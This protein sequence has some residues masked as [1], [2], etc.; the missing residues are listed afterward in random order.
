[1]TPLVLPHLLFIT[2][3]AASSSSLVSWDLDTT[4]GGLSAYGETAQWSWGELSGGPQTDEH[5]YAWGTGV[6]RPYLNDS[7]DYLQLPSFDLS[8]SARPVLRFY[9]WYEVDADGTDAGW[10]EFWD[11]STWSRAEPIYDY[12]TE[13]GYA[14]NSNGWHPAWFDLRGIADATYLRFAFVAD[15]RVALAGWF[16]DDIEILDGDPVPPSVTLETEPE[17]TQDLDG[18]YTVQAWVQDDLLAPS[19][20]LLWNTGEESGVVEMTEEFTGLFL[21]EIPGQAP[22]TTVRW[23]V[24][25]SDG[26]NESAQPET[27]YES[28]RVYLAA[29]TG[30]TGPSGRVVGTTVPLQWTPPESDHAVLGYHVY[31]DDVLVTTNTNPHADAPLCS[32]APR[33]SVSAVYRE[34]EGDLSDPLT[35]NAAIPTVTAMEPDSAWQGERVRLQVS[36][37]YLLLVPGE[38]SLDLGEG[39]QVE[40][41]E[42]VDSNTAI[43]TLVIDAE[44]PVG[45]REAT[46]LT[47]DTPLPLPSPLTLLDGESRP[48][49]LS[50][51][52]DALTQGETYTLEITANADFEG[53][54][55]LD[56]GEGLVVEAITWSGAEAVATVAVTWSAPIGERAIEADDGARVLEGA[57]LRVR[58]AATD[59]QRACSQSGARGS[60]LLGALIAGLALLRARRGAGPAPRSR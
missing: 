52:P 8:T 19:A 49:L 55:T 50:V 31:C 29:P 32:S 21:G 30:L 58:N 12:P 1:M 48:R 9:H 14:G 5:V 40:D 7:L 41:V 47:G 46:L 57:T 25:A 54:P 28:F 18:P 35:L 39:V 4:D 56:L 20:T 3:A 43:F 2:S 45:D 6:G 38:V 27:G 59:P 51:S 17:D 34:G 60:G 53:E 24:V 11:G 33:F 13:D 44:A 23:R 36:G 42:I 10:L 37:E 15:E 26:T 22:G 16:V